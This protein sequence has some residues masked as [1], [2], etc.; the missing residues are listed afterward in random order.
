MVM[1]TN[2]YIHVAELEDKTR[3]PI[4]GIVY[5]QLDHDEKI[6]FL[7]VIRGSL[8]TPTRYPILHGCLLCSSKLSHSTMSIYH[9]QFNKEKSLAYLVT[10]SAQY[11]KHLDDNVTAKGH[12]PLSRLINAWAIRNPPGSSNLTM[13]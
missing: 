11:T 9:L 4:T 12:L 1:Q 8:I 5:Q 2:Y 7:W 3:N 13:C 10:C 6:S